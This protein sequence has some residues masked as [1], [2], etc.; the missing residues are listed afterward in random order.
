MSS[1]FSYAAFT[2]IQRTLGY[3]QTTVLRHSARGISIVPHCAS[4]IVLISLDVQGGVSTLLHY[5][6]VLSFESTPVVH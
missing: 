3:S 6:R 2:I 1:C 5:A 4:R